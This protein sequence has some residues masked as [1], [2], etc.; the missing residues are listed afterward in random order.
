MYGWMAIC[1]FALFGP[2]AMA[3]D[4]WLYWRMMQCAMPQGF[5]YRISGELAV[6]PGW[7]ERVHV[8]VERPA[9]PA[10]NGPGSI[11]WQ[12]AG[13][14]RHVEKRGSRWTRHGCIDILR[15]DV[16][17]LWPMPWPTAR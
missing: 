6:D 4:H 17:R 11:S 15:A 14:D 5:F 12:G 10:V 3:P 8:G 13:K 2:Q 1:I 16:A 7:R 9:D